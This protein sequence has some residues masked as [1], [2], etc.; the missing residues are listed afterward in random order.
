M[1]ESHFWRVEKV[2]EV[3]Y[4]GIWEDLK[5]HF[6]NIKVNLRDS[7]QIWPVL[8]CIAPHF[9]V[10]KIGNFSRGPSRNCPFAHLSR[11][12]SIALAE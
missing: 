6:F 12:W 9:F 5:G 10:E 7:N 1:F 4:Y 11:P 2:N 8:S 3:L